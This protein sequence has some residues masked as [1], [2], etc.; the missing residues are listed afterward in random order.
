MIEHRLQPSIARRLRAASTAESKGNMGASPGALSW[1]DQ[2]ARLAGARVLGNFHVEGAVVEVRELNF[3]Q[4]SNLLYVSAGNLFGSETV[5]CADAYVAL[6]V[7]LM[8]VTRANGSP[9]EK[10][11]AMTL[12]PGAKVVTS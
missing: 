2:P 11:V 5:E 10:R 3:G 4:P 12:P 6:L 8:I 7:V 1:T 9:R